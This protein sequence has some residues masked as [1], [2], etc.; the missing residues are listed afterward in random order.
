M[1]LTYILM[2]TLM[3]KEQEIIWNNKKEKG[4]EKI[5]TITPEVIETPNYDYWYSQNTLDYDVA[6]RNKPSWGWANV[7]TLIFNRLSTVWT[8]VQSFTWFWFK[9]TNYTIQAWYNWLASNIEFSVWW[10]D[11]T[12]EQCMYIDSG[13]SWTS[14]Y[15]L[16]VKDW[17]N[18]TSALFSSF[19]TDWITLNF[20][21][22]DI[23]INL[24][25]TCF[26]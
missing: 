22:S 21:F 15:S 3:I 13:S 17:T 19:D 8:G 12:T 4:V 5:E 6:L 9:P 14:N 1:I 20:N 25:I 16:R 11:W 24:M 7:K 23:N 26:W 18:R 2:K 10:Y